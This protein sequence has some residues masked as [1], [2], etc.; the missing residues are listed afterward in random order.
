MGYEGVKA[1]VHHQEGQTVS[2]HVDTGV[3]LITQDSLKD[4]KIR[5]LVDSQI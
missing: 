4:P 1:I 5:E 2:K 3:E